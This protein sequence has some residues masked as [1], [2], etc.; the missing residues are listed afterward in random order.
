MGYRSGIAGLLDRG[1]TI[2]WGAI[3]TH[4]HLLE[5][6]TPRGLADR[7]L[8]LW[9]KLGEEG[10]GRDA[11]A[12]RSLLTPATCCLINPDLTATVEKAYRVVKEVQGLLST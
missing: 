5:S 7:L 11:I 1:G 9:D 4:T 10:L 8:V 6:E 2:A 12:D 3:P